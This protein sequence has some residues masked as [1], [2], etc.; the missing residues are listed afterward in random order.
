[1][2]HLF[3]YIFCSLLSALLLFPLN[4]CSKADTGSAKEFPSTSKEFWNTSSDVEEDESLESDLEPKISISVIGGDTK[5]EELQEELETNKNTDIITL[6]YEAVALDLQENKFTVSQGIAYS[7]YIENYENYGLYYYDPE[8]VLTKGNFRTVGFVEIVSDNA[9][10]YSI[11]D[12]DALFIVEDVSGSS[13]TDTEN[14]STTQNIFENDEE[15]KSSDNIINICSYTYNNLQPY[16]FVYQGKYVQYYQQTGSR[17]VYSILENKKAN[18][19][20]DYFGSLYDFDKKE[21]IYDASIYDDYS[22]HSGTSAFTDKEYK[23]LESDLKALSEQQLKN[24]YKVEEYQIV[25]IS[26]EN[27]QAY[28]DSEEEDTFFG[29]SV[30]ELTESFGLNKALEFT[31]TGFKEASV[32]TNTGVGYNWKSFLI[33]MGIGCGII[34]VGAVLTPLTGGASFGCALLTISKIAVTYAATSAVGKFAITAVEGLIAGKSILDTLKSATYSGLDGFANGFMIGSVIGSVGVVSGLIKPNACFVAGTLVLTSNTT[35]ENIEDIEVGDYVLSYDVDKQAKQKK[36][37]TEIFE[38]EVNEL[39]EIHVS[40]E[41]ITTT[42]NHPF[43]LPDY[44]KWIEAG[45]LSEGSNILLSNGKTD[46]IDSKF[47]YQTD[48][49][50]TVYNFTVEDYHTYFV[51][52]EGVLVHNTCTTKQGLRNKGVKNAQQEL[53]NDPSLLKQYEKAYGSKINFNEYGTPYL[54]KTGAK[55]EGHHVISVA[56]TYGTANEWMITDPN[57]IV[58]LTHEGHLWVHNNNYKTAGDS[59]KVLEL[60]PFISTRFTALLG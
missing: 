55:L 50:V 41:T 31:G 12:S 53:K 39:V 48:K 9:P 58:F 60:V 38:K 1:M 14:S 52:K 21:Y 20:T 35:Y 28:I 26:P 19:D 46:Y 10:F 59:T 24:G 33:K 2:K 29:Y 5:E 17:I 56:S 37:V 16:H 25:Y 32:L 22:Y 40:T 45:S 43:Y 7:D 34:L 8:I 36:K 57:N 11:A 13:D 54:A 6:I 42:I 3:R 23:Q 30:D 51:G 44:G 4:S 49:P 27:I 47:V 18:Y 15:K